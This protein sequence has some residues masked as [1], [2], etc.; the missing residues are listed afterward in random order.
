MMVNSLLISASLLMSQTPEK[1]DSKVVAASLFKNGFAVVV[2]ETP[3]KNGEATITEL[4]QAS[5]GTLWLS[6]SPGV[7]IGEAT[8]MVETVKGE[9]DAITIDEIL[10][11]NVGKDVTLNMGT[12]GT[13]TGKIV[14]A[15]GQIVILQAEG[16]TQVFQKGAIRSVTAPA[17]LSYKLKADTQRRVLHVKTTGAK[18]GKVFTLA[19][20]RGVTWSPAYAID[21]SDEKKLSIIGKATVI[22]DLADLTNLEARLITGFPNLPYRDVMDPLTSGFGV[23]QY[24]EQMMTMGG[25]GFAGGGPGGMMSQ[26][27]MKMDARGAFDQSFQISALPGQTNEDLFFYRRPNVT[28]KKGE[29]GYY[30]LFKGETEYEHVYTWDIAD[31]INPDDRYGGS[32]EGPG[33]VWHSLKFPNKTD[34]P[35]TTAVAVTMKDG[36]ILG[37]DMLNYTARGSNA[38]VKITKALDIRADQSEEE[39]GRERGAYRVPNTG[40]T[41]DLVTLKGTLEIKNRKAQDVKLSISRELT[42]EVL[43]ADNDPKI[44]KTAKGLRQMNPRARLSWELPLAAGKSMTITYT[45]KVY[46]VN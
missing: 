28:L 43:T 18:E 3:L 21:I 22:N 39:V 29:R 37:Q 16:R 35:W 33:D 41:Y 13:A 10:V 5:L 30:V 23:Q 20:E 46:L 2:R 25:G 6:T 32:P 19:L 42:G 14:S 36:E 1:A 17:G 45:Y 4:P 9:R 40:V 11:S 8:T 44:V 34:L 38:L 7:V 24:T 26:N 27:A 12:E 31:T 15:S